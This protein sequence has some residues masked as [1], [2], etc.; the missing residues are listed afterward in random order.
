MSFSARRELLVKVAP[1]YREAGR[2]QKSIILNEFIAS[3]GYKRKYA[4]RLLSLRKIPNVKKIKRPRPRIYGTRI[5]EALRVAWSAANCIASKR[6]APFLE[7][8]VPILE[9][10]GHL[11]LTEEE[12][13]LLIAIS[14]S[15]IDR[16]LK[17][18]REQFNRGISTTRPGNLL[19]HQ[20]PVRTFTDWEETI[21][22][23]FEA[24]LVGHYG[25]S[26]EG[27]VLHTLVLTDI[28][29]TWTEFLP[30][31]HRSRDAVIHALNQ[32]QSVIPFPILGFDTDN[33]S[34]FINNE[35]KAYCEQEEITFTRGR[36][37]KKNDQCFVEQKN[38][39][40]IRQFVGYDRFEGLHSYKQ[41]LE[42]YR[43][44]RLYVNFFQPSM[45]L[46][47]KKRI[48]S[49]V[50]RKHETALTPFQRLRLSGISSNDMHEKLI[51]V[52]ESL[53]PVYLLR[54]IGILQDALWRQA[55]LPPVTIP[56]KHSGIIESE[57]S[58][59]SPDSE[60]ILNHEIRNKRKYHRTK[61]KKGPR[62]WRTRP[63]PF[64]EVQDE[65]ELSL[66]QNPER[67]AKSILQDLQ[68]HYGQKY[69][70]GQLRTLQRRVQAWRANAV[71]TFEKE[72]ID[73][74]PMTNLQKSTRLRGET[75][76]S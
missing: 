16:I 29:T 15:T 49:Q 56:E 51:T 52:Y 53:D 71:I 73:S 41:L 26:V 4:I 57:F 34:E 45:K 66:E 74:D 55:V 75:Y 30:L 2:K 36:V 61:K 54:Q 60:Y 17:P 21:P 22:G 25:W 23:F 32:M 39:N 37:C 58:N 47:E 28:A 13:Y 70:D 68:R 10:H 12:R 7:E 19:K 24:D 1:R 69:T 76:H 63:D 31:L 33:G 35:V 6:L 27:A 43:A 48:H 62:W 59:E 65:I 38:G 14:P 20:I 11:D 50:K 64:A 72:W 40:I 5:Q 46:K 9:Y 18:C 42:L 3:T 44:L 8:L 67:T